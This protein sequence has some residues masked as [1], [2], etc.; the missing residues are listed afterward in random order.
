VRKTLD[1]LKTRIDAVTAILEHWFGRQFPR[2]H[3]RLP[4]F[5]QL[6]RLNRPIGIYLL[7]WPTLGALWVAAEGFPDLH[8]LV[9]FALGTALMR[10]AGCAI[11]DFADTKMP[12]RA[13]MAM[14][15]AQGLA[16]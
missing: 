12:I 4:A 1:S 5:I 16:P 3:A 8:L 14:C 15:C 9:I 6:T 10:S 2:A 13:S 7:L 11:N